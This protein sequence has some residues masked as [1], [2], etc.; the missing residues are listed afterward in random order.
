MPSINVRGLLPATERVEAEEVAALPLPSAEQ[1]DRIIKLRT[2]G[3]A[4]V[5]ICLRNSDDSYA[6]IQMAISE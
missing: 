2:G 4:K 1:V 6:W 3:Q 5:Y